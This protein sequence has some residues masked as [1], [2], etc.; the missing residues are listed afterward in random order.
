MLHPTYYQTKFL[1][2]NIYRRIPHHI[3]NV[4][5]TMLRNATKRFLSE[6]YHCRRKRDCF[7]ITP[8]DR[9]LKGFIESVR[10]TCR[11][12]ELRADG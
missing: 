5:V 1:C 2:P 11:N 8:T 4:Y 12:W 10:A 3:R 9:S 7:G 6:A